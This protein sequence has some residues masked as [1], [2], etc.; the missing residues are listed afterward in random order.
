MIQSDTLQDDQL[1]FKI[2]GA[3]NH[4]IH[5]AKRNCTMLKFYVYTLL[6]Q[7]NYNQTDLSTQI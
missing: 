1:T 4:F 6:P 5:P 2:I 7:I 3:L